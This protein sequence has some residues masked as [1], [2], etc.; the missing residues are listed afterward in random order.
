MNDTYHDQL[1]TSVAED[2]HR[3]VAA[4]AWILGWI[5]GPFPALMI[6]LVV[7]PS[8]WTRSLVVAAAVFWTAMW[9]AF[10]GVLYAAASTD[11]ALVWLWWVLTVLVA[12][13]GTA[14]GVSIAV[15]RSRASTHRQPW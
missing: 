15:R 14:I 3:Q 7:R 1:S 2:Q 11:S 13:T 6:W 5:G 8:S 4:A 9:S 12:F 10:V